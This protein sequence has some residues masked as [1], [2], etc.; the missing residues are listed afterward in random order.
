[1]RRKLDKVSS[2]EDNM[3][4]IFSFLVMAFVLSGTSIYAGGDEEE[5]LLNT[6]SY[7]NYDLS[8]ARL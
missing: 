4:K 5:Q 2:T 7:V 8:N 1:M 3:K 6:N